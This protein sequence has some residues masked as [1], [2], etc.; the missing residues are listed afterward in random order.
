MSVTPWFPFYPSDFL[1]GTSGMS[2]EEVGAYIKLIALLY[3]NQNALALGR[4]EH[5]ITGKLEKYSYKRM[6][7]MLNTRS[8]K[9]EKLVL[10]LI[11]QEKISIEAGYLT[12]RRVAREMQK[13]EAISRKN[14]ENVAKRRDRQNAKI[15]DFRR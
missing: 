1:H 11:K 14:R 2:L 8:D 7:R 3:E 15:V 12:N 6:G 9:A 13:R 5:P 4:I 10:S